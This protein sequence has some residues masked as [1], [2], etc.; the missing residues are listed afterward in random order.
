MNNQNENERSRLNDN[1]REPLMQFPDNINFTN[2]ANHSEH[3]E[4]LNNKLLKYKYRMYD[5]IERHTDIHRVKPYRWDINTTSLERFLYRAINR[6][7]SM[8]NANYIDWDDTENVFTKKCKAECDYVDMLETE[9]NYVFN[10]L[11]DREGEDDEEA[12][13]NEFFAGLFG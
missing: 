6:R 12:E 5:E 13:E 11:F 1:E 7:D 8:H 2:I 3:L 10:N 4:K 9:I